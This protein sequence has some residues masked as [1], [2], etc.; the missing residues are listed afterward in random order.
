[1]PAAASSSASAIV[2]L[3][4]AVEQSTMIEPG[5]SPALSPF[6]PRITAST[7]REPRDA[8]ED[9]RRARRDLFGRT[10]LDRPAPHQILD[11]LAVA[12]PGD[13]QAVALLDDVLGD[14]VPHQAQPDK[15]DRLVRHLASPPVHLRCCARNGRSVKPALRRHKRWHVAFSAP[16]SHCHLTIR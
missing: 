14:A 11:R 8:D 1:M 16:P 13:R 2:E 12:M 15:A 5:F 9:D 4:S 3:G 6:S 10:H 7:S